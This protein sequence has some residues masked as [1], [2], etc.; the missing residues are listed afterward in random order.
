[1]LRKYYKLKMN[2]YLKRKRE[3]LY[4]L[5]CDKL[6]KENSCFIDKK[7]RGAQVIEDHVAKRSLKFGRYA[8]DEIASHW[9]IRSIRNLLKK[10]EVLL[11][12]VVDL[13]IK[14]DNSKFAENRDWTE[15]EYAKR[16]ISKMEHKFR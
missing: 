15:K 13:H 10:K 2:R 6:E 3:D 8:V 16:A 7:D 11:E 1:M 9:R 4:N 14:Y 5:T 12:Y